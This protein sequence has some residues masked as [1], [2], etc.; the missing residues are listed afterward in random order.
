MSFF[1]SSLSYQVYD[2]RRGHSSECGNPASA[3]SNQLH[4]CLAIVQHYFVAV[5]ALKSISD[6]QHAH[7]GEHNGIIWEMS[8]GEAAFTTA[9]MA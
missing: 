8:A 1:F 5:I 4:F 7:V 9:W 6:C 2:P 3:S